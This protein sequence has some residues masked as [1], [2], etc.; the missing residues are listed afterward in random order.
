[1]SLSTIVLVYVAAPLIT[2]P[3]L[4]SVSR[5]VCRT[6][7][8][9]FLQVYLDSGSFCERHELLGSLQMVIGSRRCCKDS[10]PIR[11]DLEHWRRAVL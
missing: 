4:I 3:Q 8:N 2:I 6:I 5:L 9:S 10:C 1:M 7:V 11:P